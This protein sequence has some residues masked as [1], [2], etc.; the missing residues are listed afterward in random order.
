M[1]KQKKK[2]EQEV[3]AINKQVKIKINKNNTFNEFTL[4]REEEKISLM[5]P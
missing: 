1:I 5:L 3:K 4:K 2:E